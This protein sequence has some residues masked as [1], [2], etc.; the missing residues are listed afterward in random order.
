MAPWTSS[1][2]DDQSRTHT[3]RQHGGGS[4][5]VRADV[6]AAARAR[7][8]CLARR[9]PPGTCACRRRGNPT[10]TFVVLGRSCCWWWWRLVDDA[11]PVRVK[12]AVPPCHGR[13]ASHEMGSVVITTSILGRIGLTWVEQILERGIS[14]FCIPELLSLIKSPSSTAKPGNASPHL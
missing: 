4:A 2:V 3:H 5:S 11:V 7:D 9:L 10:N 6:A 14:L 12:P 8:G 13:R 1:V